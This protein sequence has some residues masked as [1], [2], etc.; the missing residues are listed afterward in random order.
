MVKGHKFILKSY[1]QN[2]SQL[3]NEIGKTKWWP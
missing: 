1:V 2:W 3:G